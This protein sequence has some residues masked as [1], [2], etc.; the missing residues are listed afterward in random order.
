MKVNIP[1]FSDESGVHILGGI[2]WWGALTDRE[3]VSA[4]TRVPISLPDDHVH[5]VHSRS[6]SHTKVGLVSDRDIKLYE[7]G[8]DGSDCHVGPI[9]EAG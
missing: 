2:N 9:W 5:I 1:T 8:V 7:G 4:C 3:K 6:E